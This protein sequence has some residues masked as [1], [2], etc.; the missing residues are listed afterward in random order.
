ACLWL[1]TLSVWRW[2][3]TDATDWLV[4]AGVFAAAAALIKFEGV[5]R[6]GVLAAAV[7]LDGVV[8]RRCRWWPAFLT[9]MLPALAAA[10]L[11]TAFEL[12]HGI[13]PDAEHLGSFQ[14]L[15]IGSVLAAL[16]GAFGG[17]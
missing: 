8:S 13:A 2:Q 16:V 4:Q 1:A 15:A 5:P 11:W 6:V 14:P 9:V 10:G 7:V 12:G 3:Q 17:V